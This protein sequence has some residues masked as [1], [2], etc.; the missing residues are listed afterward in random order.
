M[1]VTPCHNGHD[2]DGNNNDDHDNDDHDNDDTQK[3]QNE[4]GDGRFSCEECLMYNLPKWLLIMTMLMMMMLLMMT[5]AAMVLLLTPRLFL[6]EICWGYLI[7]PVCVH[8]TEI[9]HVT[10][11]GL[12]KLI[13]QHIGRFT[14][15]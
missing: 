6:L 3:I 11:C 14:V 4:N 1:D 2:E 13:V 9:P 12:N 7:E 8:N 10:F 5:N 15:K